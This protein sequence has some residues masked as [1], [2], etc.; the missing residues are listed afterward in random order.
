MTLPPPLQTLTQRVQ[1]YLKRLQGLLPAHWRRLHDSSGE[2]SLWSLRDALDCA[3]APLSP[4]Q[5]TLQNACTRLPLSGDDARFYGRERQ[6]E[7]AQEA[8]QAWRNGHQAMVVVSGPPGCGL[9]SFLNRLAAHT[10]ETVIQ[11]QLCTRLRTREDAIALIAQVLALPDPPSSHDEL[12]TR[13]NELPPHMLVLDNAHLL[14]FRAMGTRNAVR[15]LGSIMVATQHHHLWILGCQR[16]AWRRLMY[17]HQAERYFSHRIELEFFTTEE[18]RDVVKQR[19]TQAGETLEWSDTHWNRLQQISDG[20]PDLAFLYAQRC[21]NTPATELLDC[22]RPIDLSIL[23]TLDMS[24]LF[25]LAELAVHGTLQRDELQ[26]IFRQTAE[27]A[28]MQLDQFCN[29]GLAERMEFASETN[30]NYYRLQPL[31]SGLII[32]Y[33]FKLNYLY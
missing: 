22:L 26:T 25:G 2:S 33:L 14:A 7:A 17:T 4:Q 27:S 28:Q 1:P 15:T 29:W 23:K 24:D 5:D 18:L 8:V 32:G 3:A 21:R 30:P 9:T 13:L 31:L 12:I 11:A 19:F 16:Q 20:K 10:Q 6:L